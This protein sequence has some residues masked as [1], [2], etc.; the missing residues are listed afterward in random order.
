MWYNIDMAKRKET[1]SDIRSRKAFEITKNVKTSCED[2]LQ[3]VNSGMCEGYNGDG[4]QNLGRLFD[5]PGWEAYEAELLGFL[6]SDFEYFDEYL[7]N[8]KL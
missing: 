1:K 6:T 2:I 5:S 4:S 3:E 7:K 8:E